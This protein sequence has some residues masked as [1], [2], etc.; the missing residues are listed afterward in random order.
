MSAID[1]ILTVLASITLV[2]VTVVAVECVAALFVRTASRGKLSASRGSVAILIPA[3]NE[4]LSIATT[5]TQLR[6]QLVPG[7]RL[8]VVADN[9]SDGTALA[10]RQAGAEVIER[11]DEHQRGKGFALAFG[12][13]AL[14]EAPPAVVVIVD[15][16]CR[17]EPGGIAA[18]VLQCELTKLPAQA[19]YAMTAPPNP[20]TRDRVSGF[21]FLFKNIVR[22]SGLAALGMP[23]LLT[24]S[25]MA[26]PWDAIEKAQLQT[27]DIVE[28]MRIGIELAINGTPPMFCP[29]AR[30]WSALPGQRSAAYTQRTR[31]EHGH[32]A[33]MLR[34]V[35]R[36]AWHGLS[37]LRVKLIALALELGV[38]PL[39]LLVAGLSVVIVA[40]AALGLFGG[41]W[42]PL[43]VAGSACALLT[44]G[45]FLGWARFGREVISL[46]TL[47]TVPIYLVWKLPMYAK[48]LFKPQK[49]WVRTVREGEGG[50]A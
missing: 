33:S 42:V 48:F 28:D 24:G 1:I 19:A 2:P 23:C 49:R 30:V 27:G 15:A 4:E 39:S 8:L 50:S 7:D 46:S 12:V 35:P 5:V 44:L 11:H 18:L 21:A 9:C 45:V 40:C 13:D 26:F 25:G 14:R 16:D 20:S 41:S 38:P 17:V 37:K 29:A 22:P 43:I 36:L 31:W 34:F 10:A 6:E 47:L 3:H 32:L